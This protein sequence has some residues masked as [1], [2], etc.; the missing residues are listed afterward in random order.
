MHYYILADDLSR[1]TEVTRA[2]CLSHTQEPDN[3]SSPKLYVDEESGMVVRLPNN[4][5]AEELAR[6]NMRYIWRESK[7][8]ERKYACIWKETEKCG[9][10]CDYCIHRMCRTVG[11]D[12]D[13]GSNIA[14]DEDIESIIEDKALLDAL[15]HAL[16][17][18]TEADRQLIKS[19][20]WDGKTQR[21]LAPELGLK[22]PKS[23][24]KRKM[25]ILGILKKDTALKNY[26][27]N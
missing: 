8:R 1:E 3:P 9:Q 20:F 19:I 17:A 12:T 15:Y 7:Y 26:F 22:E 23:V 25:R 14:A 16:A 5:E 6:E 18:L 13:C 10:C 4:P 11:L 24:N 21:E 2:E 27:N